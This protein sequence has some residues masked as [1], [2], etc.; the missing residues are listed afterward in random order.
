MYNTTT[1]SCLYIQD[2]TLDIDTSFN[3]VLKETAKYQQ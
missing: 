3:N 1:K 2:E